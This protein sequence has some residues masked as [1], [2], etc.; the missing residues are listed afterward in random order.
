[1]NR[2]RLDMKTAR[3][4]TPTMAVSCRG[5]GTAAGGWAV[6]DG[7]ELIVASSGSPRT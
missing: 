7:A 5:V 3:E 1:M 2:S 6:V 4:S